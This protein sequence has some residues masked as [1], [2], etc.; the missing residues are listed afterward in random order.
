MTRW[1]RMGRERRVVMTTR[2]RR[3]RGER[4]IS[5]WLP[6]L[7]ADER[8]EVV[9]VCLVVRYTS[10]RWLCCG[11][12]CLYA[13][14]R[15]DGMQ[16][17][18]S[19]ERDGEKDASWVGM[20]GAWRR[21]REWASGRYVASDGEGRVVKKRMRMKPT[22]ARQW[23]ISMAKLRD[24][25]TVMGKR[26][27]ELAPSHATGGATRGSRSDAA[28]GARGHGRATQARATHTRVE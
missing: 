15:Y 21:V 8:S 6:W 13:L 12:R 2:T 4:M 10:M 7:R 9:G 16:P 3:R 24:D 23:P 25:V 27:E 26:E 20:R 28:G 18:P 5:S 19:C 14:S 11:L 22:T 1:P 17:S